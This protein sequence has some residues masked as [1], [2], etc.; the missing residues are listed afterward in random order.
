M[1]PLGSFLA[2]GVHPATPPPPWSENRGAQPGGPNI[3]VP[4][5]SCGSRTHNTVLYMW[6][7]P[8]S[9]RHL[10]GAD[11]VVYYLTTSRRR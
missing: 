1:I 8:Q 6:T 9:A 7:G 5:G 4:D 2:L 10:I 11:R 3:K